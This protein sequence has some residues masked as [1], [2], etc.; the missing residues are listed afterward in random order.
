MRLLYLITDTAKLYVQFFL[1]QNNLKSKYYYT[2]MWMLRALWLVVA[3]DLSE[4][5]YMD[6]VTIEVSALDEHSRAVSVSQLIMRV[7]KPKLEYKLV[8]LYS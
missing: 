3:H 1:A 5:R 6:D 2:I 4:Y 8:H 7:N